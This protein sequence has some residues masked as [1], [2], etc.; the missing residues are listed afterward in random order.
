MIKIASMA[1]IA[2]VIKIPS[3][4][5]IAGMIKIATSRRTIAPPQHQEILRLLAELDIPLVC[6]SSPRYGSAGVW[7]FDHGPF[8]LATRRGVHSRSVSI[9]SDGAYFSCSIIDCPFRGSITELRE[10]VRVKRERQAAAAN[11][12]DKVNLTGY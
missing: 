10:R 5:R 7:K 12:F 9:S 11:E 1:K 8:D 4:P 6:T 3:I 2:N